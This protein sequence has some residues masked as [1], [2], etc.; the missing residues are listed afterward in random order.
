MNVIIKGWIF[1]ICKSGKLVTG[2]GGG[3]ERLF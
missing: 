3:L 2:G 1:M